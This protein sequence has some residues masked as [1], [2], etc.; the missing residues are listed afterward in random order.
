MILTAGKKVKYGQKAK[1]KI[2]K[3]LNEGSNILYEQR[4]ENHS[5][6]SSI[7]ENKY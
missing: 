7:K 5:I 1:R 6:D 3:E 4:K 2:D